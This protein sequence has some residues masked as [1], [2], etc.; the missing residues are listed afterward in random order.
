MNGDVQPPIIYALNQMSDMEDLHISTCFFNIEIA[1]KDRLQLLP[2]L[3]CLYLNLI[4]ITDDNLQNIFKTLLELR[5]LTLITYKA[6][7]LVKSSHFLL[8]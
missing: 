1:L 5:E 3:T 8:Y 7:S 6:V 2:R 4:E